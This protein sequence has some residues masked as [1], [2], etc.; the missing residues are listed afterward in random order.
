ME[1]RGPGRIGGPAL[2]EVRPA[3]SPAL[4]LRLACLS[5][6]D[7]RMF[8]AILGT[9]ALSPLLRAA[10]APA[11]AVPASDA[12]AEGEPK[13]RDRKAEALDR[14]MRGD[15]G[16][17]ASPDAP[18]DDSLPHNREARLVRVVPPVY[19]NAMAGTGLSAEVMLSVMVDRQ[20]RASHVRVEDSSDPLFTDAAMDAINQWEFLPRVREG[21]ISNARMRLTVLVAE[22]V[23]DRAVHDYAGGRIALESIKYDGPTDSPVRR[24]FGL[25]PVYP[26]E[27]L[28]SR[29]AG[30]VLVECVVG[31]DG[32]PHDIKVV[33]ATHREFAYSVQGALVHWR[34]S[35][36]I[37]DGQPVNARL[38]YR[39]SFQPAE[40]DES[41][42]KLATDLRNGHA[43][44]IEFPRTLS[45][46]PRVA[47]SINP[48]SYDGSNGA[49][50]RR[51]VTVEIVVTELGEVR[52]PRVVSAPDP[53]SGYM[54]LAAVAYWR[55]EPGRKN[56]Q[57]VAVDVSLPITF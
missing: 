23:G 43:P 25:R 53:L 3:A 5:T 20:G 14:L 24:F 30:E 31:E 8:A 50:R 38:R 44:G 22:E 21:R 18:A 4:R 52:L 49:P 47:R 57:P 40:L 45:Q 54:A 29:K 11:S 15:G 2:T 10:D 42:L 41:L 28:L 51:R 39:M 6:W 1:Q 34:F 35:P 16:T 48:S 26:F 33:E 46:Q 55:F 56:E 17:A 36:A 13:P 27:L 32:L 7:W 19:P 37:K 12:P 9:L